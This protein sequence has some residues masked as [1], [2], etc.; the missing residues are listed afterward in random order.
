MKRYLSIIA[1]ALL[2]AAPLVA[3][4]TAGWKVRADK[5]ASASDPDG[6][7][8]IK[9]MAMGGGFHAV[10]PTAA[11]YWNPANTASGTYTLKGT[12]TLNEPSDHTNYYGLIF[13]GH[14]LDGAGENYTYFLVAQNGT[15]LV[16]KRSGETTENVVAKTPSDAV[17]KPDASGKSVNMLEV[18]VGADKIDYVV[19]GT[20]VQSTPKAGVTTDGTVGIRVN[21]HLNV[22]INDF[23]VAK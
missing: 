9:F 2:A 18:R 5:S 19:N 1:L 12:F 8:D 17:K 13:G 3:Q 7:G 15:F 6:A 11:V 23:A 10:N 14:D 21:H 20:V 4:S 16:K 22:S